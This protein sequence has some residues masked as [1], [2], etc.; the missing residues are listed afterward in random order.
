VVNNPGINNTLVQ[1]DASVKTNN[2][3]ITDNT[4]NGK[5]PK[6]TVAIPVVYNKTA[7]NNDRY[8]DTDEDNA[9]R[10]KVGG[11]FRKVKRLIERNTNIKT[12]NEVKVAGFE[13]AIK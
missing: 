3:L 4:P 6:T 12:G 8:L 2:T 11:F 7:D 9:K 1:P 5:D 13:I 10:T